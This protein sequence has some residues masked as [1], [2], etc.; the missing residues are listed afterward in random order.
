M[1]NFHFSRISKIVS[2]STLAAILIIS[3]VLFF[4]HS[5]T[6]LQSKNVSTTNHH[7]NK[8]TATNQN[9]SGTESSTPNSTS[10]TTNQSTGKSSSNTS[11]TTSATTTAPTQSTPA[12]QPT[13][14][15]TPSK[16]DF[17]L[18][19]HPESAAI[20]TYPMIPGYSYYEIPYTLV[21]DPGLGNMSSMPGCTLVNT[22][23]LNSHIW[24]NVG[25][26]GSVLS[27]QYDSAA[28]PGHYKVQATF[29]FGDV[30]H[31]VTSEFDL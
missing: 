31:T 10:S 1:K 21:L 25:D 4:N 5:A 16:P 12:A 29:T 14:P 22:P 24:C 13:S 9:T 15:T 6:P 20:H 23:L 27:I 2:I 7:D 26:K 8:V 17:T 18:T 28:V 30:T 11:S 19:L 3:A